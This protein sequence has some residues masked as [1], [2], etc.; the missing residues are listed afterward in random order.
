MPEIVSVTGFSVNKSFLNLLHFQ[1][2]TH[3]N[4]VHHTSRRLSCHTSSS[5]LPD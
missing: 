2:E 5:K 3:L 1:I 4:V